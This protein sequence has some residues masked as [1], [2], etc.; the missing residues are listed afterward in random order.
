VVIHGA[1]CGLSRLVPLAW[2]REPDLIYWGDV[3]THGFAILD[4][5]RSAFLTRVPC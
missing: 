5:L 3:D 4:Q 1:G 2:L